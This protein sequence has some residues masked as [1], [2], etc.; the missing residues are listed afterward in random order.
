MEGHELC[1]RGP[2]NNAKLNA[3]AQSPPLSRFTLYRFRL[4]KRENYKGEMGGSGCK[5][6]MLWKGNLVGPFIFYFM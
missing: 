1:A 6:D 5:L 3:V 4:V 2:I